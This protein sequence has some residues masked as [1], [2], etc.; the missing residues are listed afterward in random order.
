M[1]LESRGYYERV[2]VRPS[3]WGNVD[4]GPNFVGGRQTA[5]SIETKQKPPLVRPENFP[6]QCRFQFIWS[7]DSP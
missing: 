2:P 6:H 7:L 1:A 3:F 4:G 5:Y